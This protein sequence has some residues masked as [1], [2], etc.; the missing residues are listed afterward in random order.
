MSGA[1]RELMAG[2]LR[3]FHRGRYFLLPYSVLDNHG[4]ALVR[5][6][7]GVLLERIKYSWF[8]WT[9]HRLVSDF[10]RTTPVWQ[11][12]PYDRIVRD[13]SELQRFSRYI[14]DNPL[15]RWPELEY[16][17]MG[18]DG[19]TAP[20]SPERWRRLMVALGVR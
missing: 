7:R 2:A 6:F 12:E 19:D 8:S 3:F 9:S 10:G 1:E 5:P 11:G 15:R 18:V 17:Y 4:H 14:L 16:P 20:D 13:D